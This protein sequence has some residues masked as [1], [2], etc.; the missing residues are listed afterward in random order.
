MLAAPLPVVHQR[1][2][3]GYHGGGLL[4]LGLPD[5][6]GRGR[7]EVVRDMLAD[8]V[9]GDPEHWSRSAQYHQATCSSLVV[10]A[11]RNDDVGK[12]LCGDAEL[13]EGGLDE[14]YVLV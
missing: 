4:G 12:L 5:D 1:H 11:P 9:Y 13:L 2:G 14:L 3:P 6:G 7:G 10:W 8:Q